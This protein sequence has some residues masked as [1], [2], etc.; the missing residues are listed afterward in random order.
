MVLIEVVG[1]HIHVAVRVFDG[2]GGEGKS[3]MEEILQ[4]IKK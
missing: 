4:W 1:K 2:K 3:K